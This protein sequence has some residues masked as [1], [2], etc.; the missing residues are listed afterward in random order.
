MSRTFF[1]LL[2][3]G[4]SLF[5]VSCSKDK[6]ENNITET[7]DIAEVVTDTTINKTK[8]F[9]LYLHHEEIP[10]TLI[11]TEAPRRDLIVMN[12]WFHEYVKKFKA[13]NPEIK[14]LVY[15]D[16]T[17]TRSYA[18]ENGEDNKYLPTGVGFQ[19]ADTNHPEWFL[20]DTNENRLEYTGYPDHWQ[21]DI[22]N[23]E[24]QQQW[25][26]QV[27]E[28]LVTNDWDGVLMDNAIYTLDTYHENVFP[29]NYETNTEFQLAY[30]SMLTTINTRLKADNK[31]GIAN[32]TNTRLYPG[33]W[34]SYLQHLD[35]GLD[36]W[37]LVFSNGNYLSDYAEGYTPQITEVVTNEADGK[38]TLVQP[39]SSTSDNQGFYYAFASYWLVN[40]GNTYFSEQEVT[41]AYKDPSPW[42]EEYTW[43]F[44]K[45]DSN[46]FQVESGVFRRNFSHT[47]VLVNANETG[48]LEV[49]LDAPHLNEK[50]E[51]V[52]SIILEALSGSVLRKINDE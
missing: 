13:V 42:R 20:L 1:N 44:G 14:T 38:I 49:N 16:L 28:E 25:A 52:S 4:I 50:G 23:T 29:K 35:G 36:E 27:G 30:K 40:N 8:L 10:S 43:N 48:S 3:I 7:D 24:Y 2:F 46:Y 37:W 17:S 47:V 9:W 51:K 6:N 26:N 21:M 34:E 32:I 15:K 39:H 33:V 18:V 45:A 19:Y 11:E 5:F 31:T 41:D 12:A 22:G